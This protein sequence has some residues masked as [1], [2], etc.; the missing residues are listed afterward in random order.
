[1][2]HIPSRTVLLEVQRHVTIFERKDVGLYRVRTV[3][4]HSAVNLCW[5][6]FLGDAGTPIVNRLE[7][8]YSLL[9][10]SLQ[11]TTSATA[12]IRYS[13]AED[14]FYQTLDTSFNSNHG[15]NTLSSGVLLLYHSQLKIQRHWMSCNS[16]WSSASYDE[17]KLCG[18]KMASSSWIYLWKQ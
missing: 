4:R 5:S 11:S 15:D 14:L 12:Y 13:S 7:D 17:K 3:F 16:F 2:K 8:L 9:Y 18:I 1:M 6:S 10:V